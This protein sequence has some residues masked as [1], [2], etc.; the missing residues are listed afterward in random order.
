MVL[1]E[2]LRLYPTVPSFPRLSVKR[3]K[4]GGY[5]IPAGALVAVSQ[6]PMNRSEKV[7]GEDALSFVPERFD[8]G[9][10]EALR[11]LRPSKPVGMYIVPSGPCVCVSMYIVPSHPCVCVSMRIV[12][13]G[14]CV[15]V[16]MCIVPS[17]PCVCVSMR[18]VPSGQCVCY[19][20]ECFVCTCALEVRFSG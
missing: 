5:D 10:G 18:I 11:K 6:Q 1:Y 13:S 4:L 9:A 19:V 20:W 16:G 2:T 14:P 3:T 15:C 12:P 8:P 17:G 7:W